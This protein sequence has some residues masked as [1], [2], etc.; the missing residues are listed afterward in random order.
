MKR[1]FLVLFVALLLVSGSALAEKFMKVERDFGPSFAGFAQN[2]FIVVLRDNVPEIKATMSRSGLA[3]TGNRDLDNI[4]KKYGVSSFARQFPG[5]RNEAKALPTERV[6]TKY[7][8]IYFNEGT[9][10]EAM[11]EYR[12]LPFIEKVE[13]VA[14]HYMSLTPNDAYYDDPPPEY[15]YDQWHY[16]DTYGIQADLGWDDET[17]SSDV[18]CAVIDG[19]VRYYH[20]DLG[21]TDP[22]GPNDNVTNGNIWVNQGEVPGNGID[23]DNNGFV[24]DVIGWDFVVAGDNQC[25]DSDCSGVDNDPRDFGGHGTHVSG[26]IAA[27]T[28]NDPTF[29]VAGVAGGWN[30]GTTS[31]TA[32][33]VKIMCL[34]A[35][36]Q[37]RRGGIMHMDYCAEAMFYV[38]TMVDKGVNVAAVNCSWGSSSYGAMPAA[39]DN[40]LAHDVMIIVAAGNSNSSSYDY[41][42]GR[43]DCMDVGAT[44]QTGYAAS[45]SNYGSWVD[46]AAPGVSILSTYHNSDDPDYDYISLMDGTSMSCPH[47]VG[48]AGLLE[49]K[50]PSLS[51]PDKFAIIVNN[52]TPYLGT[53][54]VGSGIISVKKALDAVGPVTNPPVADFSGSPTSG[55]YPLTVNFTD[56]STNNPTSW[57]WDFGDGVGTS[58]DQNP[59]Y[60]YTSAGTFTVTLVATNA[61]GS[62]SEVKNGYITVTA[63]SNDP[64]VAD[65]S[66]D[67]TSGYVPLAVDFTDL[68]TNSPTSW[69]WDFGDGAGTSTA[70]NPSY[71]YTSTG[72]YTVTLTATNAYGSDDEIKVDYITVNEE[73]PP[74]VMHVQDIT[75]TRISL[76]RN[77]I[78][79]GEILIQDELGQ[80]VVGATVTASVT[81]NTTETLSGVTA[82]DGIATLSTTKTKSC[83]GDWCFEVTNVVLSGYSYDPGSNAVTMSC[84]SGDVYRLVTDMVPSEFRLA[85]YPNPFNPTTTIEMSLPTASRWTIGI[86]NI[87]GQKV[88]EFSGYSSAGT[89]SVEWDASD[90]ASGIYFYKGE[91]GTYSL[92]RKMILMK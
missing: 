47:V 20:Y 23:D 17:G 76:G 70:Q 37:T 4:G 48:L 51:G 54:D 5:A 69:L 24:D 59:S 21:G 64:P 67:P 29:G 72:T 45:F 61:Y 52:T 34:R 44:D 79:R 77:C 3:V 26:T 31:S 32:N 10:E 78:S 63:P 2:K 74:G 75:V 92:T 81:G 86:Y 42:G 15:P 46:V 8:K 36:Y 27:I 85:N 6:L 89:V 22:P 16:W 9:L 11:D 58:T 1:V 25:I 33:G 84:E 49:S 88:D 80:A 38:A 43:E 18:V 60:T 7:Y 82:S 41:L 65:F 83:D 35:G 39:T 28:N 30:D 19:G 56:L 62:D 50:D 66:A 53:K 55:E 57:S 87:A 14:M 73:P 13:P 68:S 40:L 90:C 91:A 71:T 12:R